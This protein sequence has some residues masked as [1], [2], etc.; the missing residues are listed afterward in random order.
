MSWSLPSEW[1]IPFLLWT[2]LIV[3]SAL[4]VLILVT[5]VLQWRADRKDARRIASL[6]EWEAIV[7]QFVFTNK[8][9]PSVFRE[10]RPEQEE[11]LR[12]FLQRFRR[13]IG[14]AEGAKLREIYMAAGLDNKL[15]ARLQSQAPRERATGALE[16]W[17]FEQYRLLPEVLTL[18]QDPVPYVAHAA[19]RTLSRS[20]NLAHAEA[21]INWV[22]SQDQYQQERLS[23]LLDDFGPNLLTWM[24]IRL[25]DPLEAPTIWRLYAML[26]GAHRFQASIDR[27]K[28]LLRHPE[29]EVVV[30]AIKALSALG[31]PRVYGDVAAFLRSEDNVLRMQ[32][33]KALDSL[34]GISAIPDLLRALE[35]PTFEVRRHAS[36]GLVRVGSGG[37]TALE[38]VRDDLY[39]DPFARD[40]AAERLEWVELQGKL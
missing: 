12:D 31:N 3:A 37:I 32:A 15:K 25:P 39:A 19:A 10:L 36:H 40:M 27:L 26:A 6:K 14:G 33:T 23:A 28:D 24:E 8:T 30:A 29:R 16:V 2:V 34:G 38:W 22:A 17:A 21:V 13:A 5:A 4:L 20:G 35:D 9:V 11:W 7:P 18:L 1:L